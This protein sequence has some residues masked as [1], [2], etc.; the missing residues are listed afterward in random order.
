[1]HPFANTTANALP[2]NI[3]EFPE[4]LCPGHSSVASPLRPFFGH[5]DSSF[6]KP[7]ITSDIIALLGTF[8]F[9]RVV[10]RHNL[11]LFLYSFVMFLPTKCGQLPRGGMWMPFFTD[12]LLTVVVPIPQMQ[13]LLAAPI[14]PVPPLLTHAASKELS[15]T[16]C[17]DHQSSSSPGP[18]KHLACTPN[19]TC[20]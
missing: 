7:L 13:G 4:P 2:N 18:L 8:P 16:F 19:L 15:R 17:C 11:R 1:L 6:L 9:I 12:P 20:K 5:L 3:K 10:H 14:F